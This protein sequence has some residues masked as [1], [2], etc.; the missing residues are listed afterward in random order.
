MMWQIY[1]GLGFILAF[2]AQALVPLAADPPEYATAASL[3]EAFYFDVNLSQRRTQSCATCHTPGQAFI[4]TRANDSGGAVSLGDDGLSF[5]TRNAPTLSY[6][7]LTPE[8]H[9]NQ[10]GEHVGG[11]FHDG[12][13]ASLSEQAA[14]PL[15]NPLE[16]ALADA[17]MLTDR[18]LENPTY[19]AS[20]KAL[21]GESVFAVSDEVYRAV[22]QSIAAFERTPGFSPFDSKYDRYLRGEYTMTAEQERGRMVFFSSLINCNRCHLLD[23]PE[24]ETFTDYSY[25]NI[26]VPENPVLRAGSNKA[27]PDQGLFANPVV[28]DPAQRGKFKVPTLRNIAL[29]GPYM[30]NGVFKDLR[31]VLV[32]YNQYLINGTRNPETGRP[33]RGAEV[34][35]NINT[36]LLREGQPMNEYRIDALIAFLETLTDRRYEQLLAN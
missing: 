24:K 6:A 4:D 16:M 11:F 33:W 25:H 30:H 19:V 36:G 32:F 20:L 3:G 14:V 31:T 27:N 23:Q 2:V 26:G 5:S 29:T 28:D 34:E 15:V 13:A 12:R 9:I 17:D 35:D 10:K 1:P 18:I 7:A 22:A 8:F 21:F